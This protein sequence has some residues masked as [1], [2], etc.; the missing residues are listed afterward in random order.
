MRTASYSLVIVPAVDCAV[1][2]CPETG[3]VPA[4]DTPPDADLRVHLPSPTQRHHVNPGIASEQ[5]RSLP[6]RSEI[7]E[8]LP[9][10]RAGPNIRDYRRSCAG[11]DRRF[12]INVILLAH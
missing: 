5:F 9:D 3:L 8:L 12:C 1:R 4:P 7:R 2:L 6:T 11:Q 10:D